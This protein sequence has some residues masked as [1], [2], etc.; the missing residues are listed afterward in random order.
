VGWL[1]VSFGY[2]L[3]RPSYIGDCRVV[4]QIFYRAGRRYEEVAL[5]CYDP[6]GIGYIKH[7]SQRVYRVY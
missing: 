2:D 7:G 6:Y 5:L 4:S 1:F 3:Y